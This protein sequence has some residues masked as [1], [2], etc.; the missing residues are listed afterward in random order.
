MLAPSSFHPRRLSVEEIQEIDATVRVLEDSGLIG[1]PRHHA[2]LLGLAIMGAELGMPPA[3]A[4][5]S[6]Y[7]AKDG[8]PMLMA[9]TVVDLC[10]R[11]GRLDFLR[12]SN[13]ACLVEAQRPGEPPYRLRFVLRDGAR[14]HLPGRI[15]ANYT[16]GWIRAR[17]ATAIARIVF[18]DVVRGLLAPEE[19]EVSD[20]FFVITG[21]LVEDLREPAPG[22]EDVDEPAAG[23]VPPTPAPAPKP[24][25]APSGPKVVAKT[26]PRLSKEETETVRR[27]AALFEACDLPEEVDA[28]VEGKR[29]SI[30]KLSPPARQALFAAYT[31]RVD[32]LRAHE[33]ALREDEDEGADPVEGDAPVVGGGS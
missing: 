13:T 9:D 18:P 24:V 31:A 4:L 12:V 20:Q 27:I 17:A 11:V 23:D 19:T 10:R 6:M 21:G 22:A 7:V 14:E 32:L 8:G 1:R 5:R 29:D 3:L 16:F 25:S 2:E 15:A 26:T 30:A 28:V 33:A